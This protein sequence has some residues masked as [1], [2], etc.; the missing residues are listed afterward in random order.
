ML[1]T[2]Y[3]T[4]EKKEAN[5]K[6]N[7]PAAPVCVNGQKLGWSLNRLYVNLPQVFNHIRGQQGFRANVCH[8]QV[9]G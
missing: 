4:P 5:R 9:C 6:G 3:G 7:Y 1:F 8:G 2:V